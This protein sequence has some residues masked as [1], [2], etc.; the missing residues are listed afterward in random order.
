MVCSHVWQELHVGRM[1]DAIPIDGSWLLLSL[2]LEVK[3]FVS[4]SSLDRP[5]QSPEHL[6]V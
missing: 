3:Q 2:N 1:S 6:L 5:H 4:C